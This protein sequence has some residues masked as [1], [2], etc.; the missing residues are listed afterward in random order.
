M[1]HL[2]RCSDDFPAA[3]MD[4]FQH[5]HFH[6]QH[7]AANLLQCSAAPPESKAARKAWMVEPSALMAG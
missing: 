2:S 6:Y 3:P 1:H 5:R 4:D 7:S